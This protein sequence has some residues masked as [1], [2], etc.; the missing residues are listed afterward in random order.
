MQAISRGES[1]SNLA[2]KY[3]V[4]RSTINRTLDRISEEG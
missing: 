4:S 2:K 3:K 1:I